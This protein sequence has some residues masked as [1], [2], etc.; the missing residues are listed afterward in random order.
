MTLMVMV[1]VMVV[2]MVMLKVRMRLM[3][4]PRYLARD[5]RM[6]PPES[7]RESAHNN[8]SQVEMVVMVVMVIMVVMI[9]EDD[10]VVD[11]GDRSVLSSDGDNFM[12]GMDTS[13]SLDHLEGRDQGEILDTKW[14]KTLCLTL[15]FLVR[16]EAFCAR[17]FSDAAKYQERKK[18][19]RALDRVPTYHLGWG[20]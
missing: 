3:V 7:P 16:T 19:H 15:S 1:R 8:S 2:M 9:F 12:Q 14:T 6:T 11:T 5:Q 18:R 10:H 17:P 20:T 13:S 4:M